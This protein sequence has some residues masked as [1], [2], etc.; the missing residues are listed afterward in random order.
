MSPGLLPH[1][2]TPLPPAVVRA[3]LGGVFGL[4]NIHKPA[5]PTSHGIVAALRRRLK[6]L[7][8][9]SG[10]DVKVGHAG[11]LDPFAEGVLMIAL[12]PAA[13]LADRVQT[14]PKRYEATIT[15]GA[16]SASD[17]TE[18][19]ITPTADAG[20][21]GESAV[22]DVLGRFVGEIVQIPPAYSAV[23]IDGQRAYMLAR[24]GD[25][26]SPAGRTVVV[27]GIQLLRYAWPEVDIEVS[28]GSGTYIRSLARDIGAALG[29][30]GYCSRLIRTAVG[31][32]TLADAVAPETADFTGDL[33]SPLAA[34]G[35]MPRIMVD[36]ALE[37]LVRF[38]RPVSL[39][40]PVEPGPAAVVSE[41]GRLIAL[42]EIGP[43]AR[44]LRV[45]KGFPDDD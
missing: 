3:Y 18:G 2:A 42:A 12:G 44:T 35:D 40:Q 32:F 37:R 1:D 16:V 6:L 24:R 17:D 15:L 13:R 8:G 33:I 19:P 11:T 34:L 28:C 29:V 20:E 25:Q 31:P 43:D 10:R 21:V 14:Q 27:H 26:P 45:V 41:S 23:H 5:G 4:L 30:G 7:P 9:R 39:P 22:R 38:G 36:R